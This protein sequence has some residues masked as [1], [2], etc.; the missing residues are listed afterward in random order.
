MEGTVVRP[1]R[2]ADAA[3][4]AL[5]HVRSWQA[6][7]RGLLPQ[8]YLDGLDPAQRV[9][10]WRLALSAAPVS[11][12]GVLVADDGEQLL[13][14]VDY[15]ASRDA[16]ISRDGDTG[17]AQVGEVNA[18]YLLPAA[19]GRGVGRLLME[20]ALARLTQA[21]FAQAT[22]WVLDTNARAR[23]FYAAGGW[24]ADGAVK[25]DD[26]R[27]FPITQLRYRKSLSPA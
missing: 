2:A 4:I 25:C 23:R 21:G 24:S 26:S 5:V 11:R 12:G 13:G 18:L 14:F 9:T 15:S 8:S 3:Q 1:A 27:G 10:R 20:A 6:A 22:L 17:R 7:Y 19:W 16:D